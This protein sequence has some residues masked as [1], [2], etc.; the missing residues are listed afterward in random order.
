[1]NGFAK[2]ENLLLAI[3][4]VIFVALCFAFFVS[5]T[6][7]SYTTRKIISDAL[8]SYTNRCQHDMSKATPT[9]ALESYG[10]FAGTTITKTLNG[11]ILTNEVD[12]WLGIDYASQPV[13][14]RRFKPVEWPPLFDGVKA[15]TEHGKVCIQDPKRANVNDQDEACLNFNVYRTKGVPLSKKLPV[16]VYIH[17]GSFNFGSRRSLDGA[18]FVASSKAPITVVS[19][20]YRLNSLGSLPSNL[21]AE[22]QLLNLGLQDQYFFLR[23]FLQ[24][25]IG[26]FGGDPKTITLGGRSAGG[27]SVGIH[28]FHNYGED[29]GKPYFARAIYQSGSVTARAFPNASYPLYTEQFNEYMAALHCPVDD[30]AAALECLRSADIKDIR[31]ISTK[32]LRK[33]GYNL[34]WPFQPVQGGP[35]LE[36]YGSES[37]YDETFF[38]VPV[39]TTSVTNEGGHFVPLNL[40]TNGQF[41]EYMRITSPGLTIDDLKELEMLYPDPVNDTSSPYRGSP[42][43][44]QFNRLSA[45]WSDYAYI[46]PTQETAYRVS[47]AGMSTWKARFNTNNRYPAWKGIPHAADA[48]YT[49]PEPKAQF[50]EVGNILHGYLSSF[51]ATGDPNTHR[52][53]GSPE[54]PKYEPKGYGLESMPPNQLVIQPEHTEVEADYIRRHACLFWRDPKRASRLNK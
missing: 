54:W 51:V 20:H 6:E 28:H 50:P 3:F 43:S 5:R 2:F 13:G 29:A 46:C 32:L 48:K 26:S 38:H 12:A 10:S 1:M 11:A 22:E 52:Y 34:T 41:L 53:P 18:A 23:H 37:G 8:C 19:F 14:E 49:W 47:K 36:K 9:V 45:A 15:A 30:N 16:F 35:M 42:K 39:I 4:V 25:H 33:S 7:A 31:K 17:G 40:S 27:H 24:K 44:E 21:F